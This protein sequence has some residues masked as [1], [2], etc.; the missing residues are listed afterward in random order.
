MLSRCPIAAAAAR[1]QLALAQCRRRLPVSRHARRRPLLCRCHGRKAQSVAALARL[2]CP[3][4]KPAVLVGQ[5]VVLQQG[6][7]GG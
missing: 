5:A 7:A 6:A 4:H 1:L 3:E 2:G